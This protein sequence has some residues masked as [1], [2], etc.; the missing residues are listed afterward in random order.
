MVIEL[1]VKNQ[2][3]E[4]SG[5][6]KDYK[7]AICEYIWN[8]L[9][10]H[11]TK[12]H[13]ESTQNI[14]CG[15]DKIVIKD[16]GDG[17]CYK[18]L[19]ETFGAFLASKK[20]SLSLKMKSGANKG[21]GRFSFIAFANSANWKTRFKEEDNI[22]EYTISLSNIQK[23]IVNYTEPTI[24]EDIETGTVV[25]F[26]DINNLTIENMSFEVL[27]PVL[28]K[29]FAWFLYLFKNKNIEIYIN[30]NKI[31]YNKY[32]DEK[33]SK[34]TEI[35]IDEHKFEIIL[36]V[37]KEK[38]K[39]KF[40]CYYFDS[41]DMLKESE[42]TTF[43]RNTVNFNHSVFVKS[44][45]FDCKEFPND[46]DDNQIHMFEKTE[47]KKILKKLQREICNIIQKQLE[48]YLSEKAE[49]AVIDMMEVK[50]TFP[51]FKNDI[52]SQMRKKDLEKVTKEIYKLEPRIFYNLKEVQEKSLLG[53]LN[54]LL[55]SEERENVLNIIEQIVEISPEQRRDFAEML[56]KT[57]LENIL[58]TIKFIEERYKVIELLKT[59]VYELAP[60]TS[61]RKHIQ[62]IIEQHFWLF[63]E[64]YHLASADQ[65]M[66]KALEQYRSILYGGSGID[67]ELEPDMEQERRMDIFLCNSRTVETT[68]QT[69]LEEN[70]IV[71]LKA[72][73]VPL[74]KKVLRQIE[75]YMDFIKRQ[76]SFNSELRRWKFIAVCK[77]V[78]DEIKSRYKAL[79]DRG[80]VG[81]V[82]QVD[83]YEVYALTW[84]DI[85]QS[86][87]LKH[88]HMLERLKYD[89]EKIASELL[90]EVK[91]LEGRD[92]VD[93]LTEIAA[94]INVN[95]NVL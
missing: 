32:I 53:F 20:N 65:R 57:T 34:K 14:A 63:G 79:E 75:D 89:R 59:L 18:E 52:Y 24:I 44:S 93:S 72:P 6:T 33:F 13:I 22:F 11:A 4:T 38:I 58:D 28:L 92:K 62:K 76:P 26:S 82:L 88:K 30:N 12:I 81:L 40:F 61:E 91:N 8:G 48:I 47:D 43:N 29:E 10:A 56:K 31:N 54:L 69:S 49:K 94:T 16:N 83:S 23:E 37:W 90:E 19:N 7:E 1:S 67:A 60:F 50:K 2:S 17:I 46:L 85:F 73:K 78:D 21:K 27:E 66:K 87:E 5:I 55:N 9:E 35:I 36:V 39:E 41:N 77:E 86:F 42:T 74:S 84:D 95:S 71:E 68:F 25:T 15:I 3:V 64:Q 45:F 70:I 51:K 80:K